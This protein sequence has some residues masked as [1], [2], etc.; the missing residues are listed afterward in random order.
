[1]QD[2][3]LDDADRQMEDPFSGMWCLACSIACGALAFLQYLV[4]SQVGVSL[5]RLFLT[6]I[7]SGLLFLIWG[8]IIGGKHTF[9]FCVLWAIALYA[10]LM[11]MLF[12]GS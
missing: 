5:N 9:W 11:N 10:V 4:S 3:P 8:L 1:M 2:E 7:A 12:G 6:L